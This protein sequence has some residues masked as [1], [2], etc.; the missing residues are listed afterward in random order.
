MA[1]KPGKD[2]K[3]K[4]PKARKTGKVTQ[5]DVS[6]PPAP[7]PLPIFVATDGA[8]QIGDQTIGQD[9]LTPESLRGL[10]LD[11][12]IDLGSLSALQ[13]TRLGEFMAELRL[14]IMSTAIG[15]THTAPPPPCPPGGSIT[16]PDE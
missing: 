14:Y 10:K 9:H 12:S 5:K 15:A 11:L 13:M 3:P 1:K 6:V 8:L 16:D 4:A 7:P 2:Q